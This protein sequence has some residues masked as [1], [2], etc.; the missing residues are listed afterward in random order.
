MQYFIK[1]KVFTLRD[2]FDIFDEH[3]NPAFKV[4]GKM[5]SFKNRLDLIL[6][7]GEMTLYAEK[8]VFTFLPE[9]TIYSPGGEA[10]A[11]IKQKFGFRPK[12]VVFEGNN[13]IRVE[14]NFWGHNFEVYKNGGVAASIV[15]KLFS[16]GDSYMID[17][18]DEEHAI[19]YLFI[20]IVIDQVAQAARDSS[21]HD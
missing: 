1:Q 4:E 8:K 20:V 14:G 3:Q 21:A 7:N 17:I 19:L 15:K 6:P 12:Y 16:F 5:F 9:Y 18:R 10:L 11:V 2:Q 13:D